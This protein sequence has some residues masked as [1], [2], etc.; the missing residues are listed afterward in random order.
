MSITFEKPGILTTLQDLGRYGYRRFGVNPNGV[1][2]QTA[3]RL[4]NILLGNDETQAV[5]EMHF[6]APQV[7]FDANAIIAIGGA[8]FT[9]M[10]DGEPLQNWRAHLV[11]KGTRLQFTNKTAGNR[12]YLAVHGGITT[13][14]WLGSASTNLTA[15]IGGLE[16]RKLNAG[17]VIRINVTE[18]SITNYE[19]QNSNFKSLSVSP[20]LIPRYTRFPT[21]RVIA[22]AEFEMLNRK[23]QSKLF[24]QDFTIATNSNRMGYRLNGE[25]LTLTKPYELVSSAVKFGTL[26]L[27]PDGQL[28]VLMADH[29]T[30]GGYPRV[31]HVITRDL[32]LLAQLGASDKVAFHQITLDEA[33]QLA[34]EFENELNFF[35]VGCRFQTQSW[36]V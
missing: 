32:P 2:D 17:D 35:R 29:Q 11:K 13:N 30:S 4:I 18:K 12:A 31:A 26:Q 3:T 36:N 27:L 14:C 22:G 24:E 8:D 25:P 16:G 10:I 7:L 6:P 5:I 15:Q 21:V 33:E 1:M 34:V 20:S 9:P 23:S 19:F 28:I